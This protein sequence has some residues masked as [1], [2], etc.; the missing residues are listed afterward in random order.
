MSDLLRTRITD[1]VEA[2]QRSK[3]LRSFGRIHPLLYVLTV[4]ITVNLGL[5]TYNSAIKS[6]LQ[7]QSSILQE[8]SSV[9][10]KFKLPSYLIKEKKQKVA[11]LQSLAGQPKQ[12]R[13]I[14]QEISRTKLDLIE[15]LLRVT[16]YSEQFELILESYRK[17]ILLNIKQMPLADNPGIS[18]QEIERE[19]ADFESRFYQ[20][21]EA[22]IDLKQTTKEIAISIYARFFTENELK[23]MIAF[24]QTAT[25]QKMIELTPKMTQES[26]LLFNKKVLP[27]L[28]EVEKQMLQEMTQQN[29]F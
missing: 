25:G 7:N 2:F 21:L 9:Q 19:L 5:S 1:R 3:I 17:Q 26:F 4:L 16:K 28:I 8:D 13:N 14:S 20:L 10:F 12:I 11:N 15:K 27:H 22:R 18:E 29:S 24:Y 23:E 6:P